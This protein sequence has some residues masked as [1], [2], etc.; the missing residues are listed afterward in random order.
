MKLTLPEELFEFCLLCVT[1]TTL[2]EEKAQVA[3]GQIVGM[4]GKVEKYRQADGAYVVRWNGENVSLA[5]AFD[6]WR[7]TLS[8][9]RLEMPSSYF[10]EMLAY[11][12]TMHVKSQHWP[13]KDLHS[14]WTA[15]S[16][17][18]WYKLELKHL[19]AEPFEVV[20]RFKTPFIGGQHVVRFSHHHGLT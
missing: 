17:F 7:Y 16:M 4:V 6:S 15:L 18:G 2:D 19:V 1:E 9:I 3:F 13:K 8:T 11:G 14:R 12:K 10:K 5:L 20:I